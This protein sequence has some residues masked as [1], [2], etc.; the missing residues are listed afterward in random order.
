MK[1]L[2]VDDIQMARN[3][4][5]RVLEKHGIDIIEAENG[6]SA[7]KLYTEELPDVVCLD[8][9]LPGGMDGIEVL[10]RIKASDPNATVLMVSAMS[11][12]YNFVE[13]FKMG[14]KN[15]LVKPIDLN[16]L[17]D[18]VLSFKK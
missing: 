4:M 7:I 9:D 15:F 1:V 16:K 5:R 18:I 17:E 6:E 11:S 8:I 10:K 3:N 13:S 12:Q 2:I 14:A